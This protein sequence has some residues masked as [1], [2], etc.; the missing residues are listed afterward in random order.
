MKKYP[1]LEI[2]IGSHAD[3]RGSDQY[4]LGLSERR[5]AAT[6]EYLVEHGI[7]RERLTS[8]GYGETMPLNDCTQPTGCSVEEYAKNRRSEFTIMN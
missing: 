7:E 3:A 2:E 4:N 1:T 6:L 5:A 8:K